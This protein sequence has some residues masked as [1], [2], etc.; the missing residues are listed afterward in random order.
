MSIEKTM[1]R[2]ARRNLVRCGE[3][4]DLEK[5]GV[6]ELIE[7]VLVHIMRDIQLVSAGDTDTAERRTEA[8]M[9]VDDVGDLKKRDLIHTETTV[10]RVESKVANDGYTVRV[11]VSEDL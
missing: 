5:Y 3:P 9:L 2:A 10:W 1:K 11:V 7:N 8:E 6:T 4:C